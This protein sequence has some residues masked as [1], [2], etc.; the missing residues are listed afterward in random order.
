MP[1]QRAALDEPLAAQLALMRPFARVN[2]PMRR[3]VTLLRERLV[4]HRASVRSFAGVR[5][6]MDL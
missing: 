3:Q 4:A 5:A 2:A 1:R 6:L